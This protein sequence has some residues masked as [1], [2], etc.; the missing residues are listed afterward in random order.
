MKGDWN[1][2]KTVQMYWK[3]EFFLRVC[4][5][6]FFCNVL[7]ETPQCMKMNVASATVLL[8][9]ETQPS[10]SR[11]EWSACSQFKF[12]KSKMCN[13]KLPSRVYTVLCVHHIYIHSFVFR[14]TLTHTQNRRAKHPS[15]LHDS[16]EMLMVHAFV[17][18]ITHIYARICFQQRVFMYRLRVWNSS[19]LL[20]INNYKSLFSRILCVRPNAWKTTTAYERCSNQMTTIYIYGT[21]I[22]VSLEF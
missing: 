20:W 4:G 1:V 13:K 21:Y 19:T 11:N 3:F 7:N 8:R 5:V 2:Y 12:R 17:L 14:S 15:M 6:I 9:L 22:Y 10:I 16:F 18:Y